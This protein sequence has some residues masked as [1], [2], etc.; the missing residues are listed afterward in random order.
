MLWTTTLPHLF[1]ALVLGRILWHFLEPSW[2]AEDTPVTT[3]EE[4]SCRHPASPAT[5]H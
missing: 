5:S 1:A 2:M 4:S 3:T